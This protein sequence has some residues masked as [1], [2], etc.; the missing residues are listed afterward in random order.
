MK[1]CIWQTCYQVLDVNLL[2]SRVRE[3][4]LSGIFPLYYPT[5]QRLWTSRGLWANLF[6]SDR[7]Q[8]RYSVQQICLIWGHNTRPTYMPNAFLAHSS[9]CWAATSRP[10][11]PIVIPTHKGVRSTLCQIAYSCT[12]VRH[13]NWQRPCNWTARSFV[14]AIGPPQ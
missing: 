9:T 4:V 1:H 6:F 14:E 2:I 7:H 13:A 3:C 5:S 12:S 10:F 11:P 8:H